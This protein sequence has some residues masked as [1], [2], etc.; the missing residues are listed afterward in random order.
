MSENLPAAAPPAQ[1]LD[2]DSGVPAAHPSHGAERTALDADQAQ[3]ILRSYNLRLRALRQIPRG[4]IN[5]NYFVD[6]DAGPAFLRINEGK[7]EDEV[8][9]ESELI[10]H[11]GSQG[12]LTP[13]LWRTRSSAPYVM[14][15]RD[16]HAAAQPVMLMTW[17]VAHELTEHELTPAHT[18]IV[19]S[20]LG[21]LHLCTAGFR[22]ARPG[23]YTLARIKDRLRRLQAD[24]RATA[25]V[26]P[27]LEELAAE[28]ADL[29]RARHRDLPAGIGHSDLFPDN[30]LF[31]SAAQRQARRHRR[32][33]EPPGTDGGPGRHGQLGW[34]LDLE[35]AATIPLVYDLAVAL[36]AFCAPADAHAPEAGPPA[37]PRLGPLLTGRAQALVAGYQS[38]R[39]LSEA[40]W[41][42]LPAE[43]RWAAVRFTTTRLTDVE[44]YGQRA[45][46]ALPE[47]P[48]PASPP[49]STA[50]PAARALEAR[51]SPGHSK[52]YRD[53]ARRLTLL[54]PRS[55]TELQT[56]LQSERPLDRSSDRSSDRPT[57][58]PSG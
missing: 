43:L 27:L 4:T 34:I 3:H 36:L 53:C 21:Q 7:S 51:P 2:P 35:Q 42:A 44:R 6:T 15:R 56:G 16:A 45:P 8:R 54:R 9:F 55:A 14:W 32:R 37:E 5:S 57:D 41:R 10:W 52:D 38:M 18:Y 25:A 46:G 48:A 28:V 40:E 12:L 24:P 22:Q 19:G 58:R 39:P 23:I 47:P 31:A 29:Q 33:P 20:L 49:P 50:A 1:G 26:G 11:L 30:L 13:Q 17:V